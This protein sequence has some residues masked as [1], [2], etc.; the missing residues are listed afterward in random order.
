M[1][2]PEPLDNATL[3]RTLPSLL[4]E[5][6]R[7][8]P[9]GRALNR[10]ADG[11]WQS[12]STGD[13]R[14]RAEALALGLRALGLEPGDPVVL[15]MRSDPDFCLADMACLIAGVP[16]V[17]IYLEH[18]DEAAGQIVRETAA[19]VLIV[20]DITLLERL[21]PLWSHTPH[22]SHLIVATPPDKSLPD[23]L[24]ASLQVTTFAELADR[25][26]SSERNAADLKNALAPSDLATIIYTSGT[27]GTPKGVMLSHENISFNAL[28]SFSILPDLRRGEE[29]ALSFLPLSHV[30]A[31]TLYY[32]YLNYGTAVYFCEP[33]QLS[34]HLQGVAPTIMA[35]VPRVLEKSYEQIR[36]K[37]EELRGVQ[38]WLFDWALRLAHDYLAHDYLAHDEDVTRPPSGIRALPYKLADR[39]VFSTWRDGFGGRLRVATA[40]GAALRPHLVHVFGAAGV[41]V[42]QGYGTTESSPVISTNR[43]HNNHPGTVGRP[44]PGT[45]VTTTDEHELLTRGPHVMQGY[46]KR[47]DDTDNTVDVDGWL[48]TGDQAEVDDDGFVRITGRLKSLFKLSTG[49]YVMPTPIEDDLEASN[50]IDYA[51]VVGEGRKYCAALLFVDRAALA[52]RAEA[53]RGD[54]DE[55][56]EKTILEKGVLEKGVL[57]K[58]VLEK[59]EGLYEEVREAVARANHTL[60]AWSQVKRVALLSTPLTTDNGL[61][62]PTL[63]VRRQNVLERHAETLR[64]LYRPD[65]AHE[66]TVLT[67]VSDEENDDNTDSS[68]DGSSEV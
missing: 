51:V 14:D 50:L 31:R 23:A 26:T 66:P 62:T 43:P 8:N 5:A 38:R 34:E 56:P 63:K 25:G 47:P 13:F 58:G 21:E 12:L 59:D 42:T 6:C 27:T 10:Y 18:S 64:Q 30:F 16:D 45:E 24:P 41:T 1:N 28:A 3:N 53:H 37:G 11:A 19:T 44:I 61:L 39:L 55:V 32:G 54:E 9:N 68:D 36:A 4:D 65:A 46:W 49:K 67:I 60:P 35:T 33:D 15:Y 17:P 29:V 57:E 7:H 22:L 48:H 40:G 2:A 52:R 20:S